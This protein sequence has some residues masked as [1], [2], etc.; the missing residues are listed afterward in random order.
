MRCGSLYGPGIYLTQDSATSLGYATIYENKYVNSQ[1][2]KKISI[3]SMFEV[4][5]L[6]NKEPVNIEIDVKGK[7]EVLNGSLNFI[8]WA[9]HLTISEAC[10]AR[11]LFVNLDAK[12]DLIKDKE[13]TDALI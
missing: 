9:Y 8:D 5:N 2:G 11:Y 10:I 6:P 3:T 7:K 13:V 1:L 4:V 12:I